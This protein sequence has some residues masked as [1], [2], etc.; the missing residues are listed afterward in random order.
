MYSQS[1][2]GLL[3]KCSLRA[4]LSLFLEVCVGSC[5]FWL[6]F[7]VLDLAAVLHVK[8]LHFILAPKPQRTSAD[9][10]GPLQPRQKVCGPFHDLEKVCGPFAKVCGPFKRSV[11][12]PRKTTVTDVFFN[13]FCTATRSKGA[14]RRG[15]A[16]A[17]FAG[18]PTGNGSNASCAEC[19]PGII[20]GIDV[21]LIVGIEATP[22][23][24]PRTG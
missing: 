10:C 4:F 8:F 12:N 5:F 11:G 21:Q 6:I 15:C 1:V 20:L 2:C 22:L 19:T 7:Q 3:V 13:R 16:R 14:T 24:T 17:P 18:W 9:L 23:S